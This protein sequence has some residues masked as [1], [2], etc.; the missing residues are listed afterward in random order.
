MTV[1][2]ITQKQLAERWAMSPKSLERWRCD[3]NGPRYLKLG[4]SRAARVIYRLADIEEYEAACFKEIPVITRAVVS[5]T[6]GVAA[7]GSEPASGFRR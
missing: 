5:M 6:D 3:G 4:T 1:V 7:Q 2:H